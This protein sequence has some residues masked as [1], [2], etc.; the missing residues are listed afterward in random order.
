MF[1][2]YPIWNPR[3]G[4]DLGFFE[5]KFYSLMFVIAFGLGLFIMS[6]IY[7]RE[8]LSEKQ[9]DSLFMYGIVSILLGARLG[10]VIFYQSE[11]FF[12]DP[13]SILL[14]FSFKGGFKFTGFAGLASHGAAI[15]MI[16]GMYIYSKKV[17]FKHP[18]WI[19]DRVVLPV[20]LGAFFV[21]MGNF[22]NSEII[23]KETT[24]RFG[25][26]FLRDKYNHFQ[27]TNY[28]GISNIND[29]Y[30]ELVSN[31]EYVALID[32]V[33][34][35][36]PTQL[37]EGF[38]YI[39]V[40]IVLMFLYWKTDSRLKQGYIFGVFMV[41]LWGIRFVV[42]FVKETQGGFEKYP[43]FNALSTGQWLSIPMIL[44]GIYFIY[45]SKNKKEKTETS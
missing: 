4:I 26:K 10:H 19:L 22:L 14:P 45:S 7:K 34:A 42:E 39:V 9:L 25:I 35:K 15:L 16:I 1:A 20:S 36:H 44:A 41:F 28:T 18:L 31:P 6:K 17:I 13:L 5:I 24:S 29:A 3:E 2:L 21:R 27:A 33:P 30:E 23:G 37:Y 11:L 38:S 40:F 43:I 12:E 32:A 8:G